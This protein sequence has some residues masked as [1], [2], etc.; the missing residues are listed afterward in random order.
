MESGNKMK[1]EDFPN[2]KK[3]TELK[4]YGKDHN[5]FEKTQ[6]FVCVKEWILYYNY[7]A[8]YFEE[9]GNQE[10]A[11]RHY[12]QAIAFDVFLNEGGW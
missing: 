7:L 12:A 1:T 2:P 8:K 10:R 6:V 9:R 11:D 5:F 4:R 3:L